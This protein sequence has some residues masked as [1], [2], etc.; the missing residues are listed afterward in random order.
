MKIIADTHVHLYPCYQLGLALGTL[1]ETFEYLDSDAVK[2]AFLVERS[3]CRFFAKTKNN[4]TVQIKDRRHLVFKKKSDHISVIREGNLILYIIPGRQIVT[5]ERIEILSLTSDAMINDGLPVDQT[6]DR[7]LNAGAIPVISWAPGKWF[8][9]RG[10][11][12]KKLLTH[13]KPSKIL[14]SDTSLRPRIW[15]RPLLMRRAERAGFKILA[16][17]DPLPFSGEEINLGSYATIIKG[18]FNPETPII[19]IKKLLNDPQTDVTQIGRRNSTIRAARRI[20]KN[21]RTKERFN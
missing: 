7:I 12:I 21:A 18:A 17:S 1:I 8:L 19:S 14:V 10:K 11:I 9:K 6:I 16:G 15:K 3:D 13:S 5:L 4:T 20:I 2:F